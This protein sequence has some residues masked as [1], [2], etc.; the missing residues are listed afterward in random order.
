[1]NTRIATMALPLPAAGAPPVL[2][3]AAVPAAP[4]APG[5]PAGAA[6]VPPSTYRALFGDE[7]RGPAPDATTYKGTDSKGVRYL[8]RRPFAT[9]R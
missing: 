7:S 1:M 3:P 4:A 5:A 8:P 6:R 2:D 9:R